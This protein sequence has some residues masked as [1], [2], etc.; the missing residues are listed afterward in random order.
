MFKTVFKVGGTLVSA[1]ITAVLNAYDIEE[2]LSVSGVSVQWSF[3]T[4]LLFFG[5]A[6]WWIISL[7]L[8]KRQRENSKPKLSFKEIHEHLVFSKANTATFKIGDPIF[9]ILQVWFINQPSV[10]TDNSIAKDVTAT[11]TF[12]DRNNKRVISVPGC[13]IVTEAFDYAGNIGFL[14]KINDWPPNDEPRKL[15]IAIKWHE[16]DSAYGFGQTTDREDRRMPGREIEKGNNYV[17]IHLKGTRVEQQPFWFTL[18]NPGKDASLCL[19][20]P[21]KKPDLRK[22]GFQT[23]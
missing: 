23:E 9:H 22:E 16:D 17:K 4:F 15:Q 12:Y 11:V 5:F 14:D 18:E 10:P 21:I 1:L 2:V 13:F 8:Y 7:Q 20:P 3:L 19:S 6:S